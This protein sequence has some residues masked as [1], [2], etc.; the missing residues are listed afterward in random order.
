MFNNTYLAFYNDEIIGFFTLS[1]D[2]IKVKDLEDYYKEKFKSKVNYKEFPAI[3]IGRLGI[4]SEYR[5]KGIGTHLLLM[6][7]HMSIEMSKKVGLRFITID[8]YL[9]AHN[10]YKKNHCND[11][12]SKEKLAIEFK[13]FKKAQIKDPQTANNMTVPMYVDLFNII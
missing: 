12:H 13:R 10:F 5:K 2:K 9:S 8:V 11:S 1:T 6:I 4:A 3:K 7:F